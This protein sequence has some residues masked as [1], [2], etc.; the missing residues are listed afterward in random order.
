M[1]TFLFSRRSIT[2]LQLCRVEGSG[3]VF[4]IIVHCIDTTSE[5][6]AEKRKHNMKKKELKRTSKDI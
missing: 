6:T 4:A 3:F 2:E 1:K 5:E